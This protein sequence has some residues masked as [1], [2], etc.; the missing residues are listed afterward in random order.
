MYTAM[1]AVGA[2]NQHY[3]APDWLGLGNTLHQ[4]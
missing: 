1:V 2:E 4:T 3:F